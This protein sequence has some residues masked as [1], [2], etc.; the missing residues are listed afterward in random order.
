MARHFPKRSA[1]RINQAEVSWGVN[2]E[3]N[4]D[5]LQ[6]AQTNNEIIRQSKKSAWESEA[7]I[8]DLGNENNIRHAYS[9]RPAINRTGEYMINNMSGGKG[10]LSHVGGNVARKCGDEPRYPRWMNT[11]DY[12]IYGPD[13]STNKKL[14]RM[15]VL[16]DVVT[17][18]ADLSL[19]SGFGSYDELSLG[20]S[21]G[22]GDL[23]DDRFA[24][25]V[26][27]GSDLVVVIWSAVSNSIVSQVTFPGAWGTTDNV[28]LSR[29]GA[30]V[31]VGDDDSTSDYRVYNADTMAFMHTVGRN[32]H[33]VMCIDSDGIT[34]CWA[35]I[36][37][38]GPYRTAR[39]F[40]LETGAVSTIIGDGTS[41]FNNGSASGGEA[42]TGHFA[43]APHR[44]GYIIWSNLDPE[45]PHSIAWVPLDGS[46]QIEWLCDHRSVYSGYYSESQAS[47]NFN[48][49]IVVFASNE[50][51]S[52][53]EINS[54]C[55]RAIELKCPEITAL[56]FSVAKNSANS[57][58]VGQLAATYNSSAVTSNWRL[59]NDLN[60]A[61]A[62]NDS[63]QIT[64]AD[65]SKITTD[66]KQTLDIIVEGAD[67]QTA[68]YITITVGDGV[69]TTLELD[70][71][72]NGAQQSFNVGR[73]INNVGY[74]GAGVENTLLGG[75]WVAFSAAG[76]KIVGGVKVGTTREDKLAEMLAFANIIKTKPG[77]NGILVY[78][79][80]KDYE[81]GI[82]DYGTALMIGLASVITALKEGGKQ[83]GFALDYKKFYANAAS[84]CPVPSYI[85]GSSYGVSWSTSATQR[86]ATAAV[87]RT[88]VRNRVM[89]LI[90]ELCTR[91]GDDIH[92]ITIGETSMSSIESDFNFSVWNSAFRYFVAEIQALIPH[93]AYLAEINFFGNNS[94]DI[95][96]IIEYFI[97]IGAV[98]VGLPDWLSG[99]A[100]W[101]TREIPGN[102]YDIN[103]YD[104][105]RNNYKHK[106]RFFPHFQTWDAEQTSNWDALTKALELLGDVD[107]F[108]IIAQ[109][110]FVSRVQEHVTGSLYYDGNYLNDLLWPTY[111]AAGFSNYFYSDQIEATQ[112]GGGDGAGSGH[113]L[114][115]ATSGFSNQTLL[116]TPRAS[117]VAGTSESFTIEFT[118]ALGT[119]ESA[120]ARYYGDTDPG[121]GD[122]TLISDDFYSFKPGVDNAS[123]D[124]ANGTRWITGYTG[125][126]NYSGDGAVIA[127]GSRLTE[128]TTASMLFDISQI[129]EGSYPIW[130]RCLG[131]NA[132]ADSFFM[133]VRTGGHWRAWE[134]IYIRSE[135]YGTL[136][137]RKADLVLAGHPELLEIAVREDSTVV[138]KILFSKSTATP[139]GKD[140]YTAISAAVSPVAKN[141]VYIVTEGTITHLDVMSN[142]SDPAGGGISIVDIYSPAQHGT[143]SVL[144][145]K[146]RYEAAAYAG[147]DSL[148]YRIIDANGEIAI[149]EVVL[150]IDES[151]TVSSL[152]VAN[153]VHIM[154][155]TTDSDTLN[156]DL[157][158]FGIDSNAGGVEFS[159][160]LSI[161]QNTGIVSI[162]ANGQAEWSGL[163]AV[164][165]DDEVAYKLRSLV[166][167]LVT[168]TGVIRVTTVLPQ[169]F[170]PDVKP[171][172]DVELAWDGMG[173]DASLD[174]YDLRSENGLR[175]AV[176]LS[177]F[178]DRRAGSDD[179]VDDDN[180]RGWWADIFSDRPIGSRLWLLDREKDLPEVVNKAHDYALEALEWLVEDG[181]AKTVEVD[182]TSESVEHLEIHVR[183]KRPN[184]DLLKMKFQRRW[185]TEA[186][187]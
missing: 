7:G 77:V 34:E 46:Q 75:G 14:V 179:N 177:L 142:D 9:E 121:V 95:V 175:T 78:G 48:G 32:G 23:F 89:A 33:G 40:I 186:D 41:L 119:D 155:R 143:A 158:Q 80:W 42:I 153:T 24:L 182:V 123:N 17:V 6:V 173:A 124:A 116:L 3:Y 51:I 171:G 97:S 176:M 58:V 187:R 130:A 156:I 45:G 114:T 135:N 18:I 71:D 128:G 161:I 87:W 10:V 141:D 36:S 63:G 115:H 154:R 74:H 5:W 178:A 11:L 98:C 54:F 28:E 12:E 101:T 126:A 82:D 110:S 132:S 96:S 170:V 22:Q 56:S 157:A 86:L 180:K 70:V 117:A 39:K 4:G 172:S 25:S 181:I 146:I 133:R 19:V 162:P 76:S 52:N 113:S 88:P 108:G 105:I 8:G 85:F 140:G 168:A 27:K 21:Q 55:I 112:Y 93:G 137:W 59:H 2:P 169:P 145:G 16:T 83:F 107:G 81:D 125:V 38:S 166:D 102:N 50:G 35:S 47:S 44:P 57:T 185:Q 67:G 26:R 165:L 109:H 122:G 131:E 66:G 91:Y 147:S 183:V 103:A 79:R 62:V 90:N 69:A 1:I 99:R 148:Q 15:N 92:L 160:D 127:E 163:G 136:F 138:D 60:T 139:T 104:I 49:T 144:N 37:Y 184:N 72:I 30:Y 111:A 151:L 29:H 64:V 174:Q 106:I 159:V 118:D 61:F 134:N 164:P 100:S 73:S 31:I 65:S 68:E 53:G 150:V 149:G 13:R 152:L 167:P 94:S 84:E 129:P 120:L 20:K 43:F